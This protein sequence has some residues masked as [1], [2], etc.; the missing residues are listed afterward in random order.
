M[1]SILNTVKKAVS[2]MPEYTVFDDEL[3]MHINTVFMGLAQMG[4]G[5]STGFRIEDATDT[6]DD[7]LPLQDE[8][9]EAVKTYMGLKVRLLFD[10]PSSSIHVEAIKQ[11]IAEL[12][13]RLHFEVES[14]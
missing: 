3:I 12:E 10:P 14:K 4:V 6:W 13:W 7:F 1:E 11:A 2:V 8:N 5:P 9:L